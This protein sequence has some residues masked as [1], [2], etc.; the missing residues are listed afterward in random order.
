MHEPANHSPAALF[1]FAVISQVLAGVHIGEELAETIRAVAGRE[2]VGFDGASQRV[3]QR[4]IYRWL[5]AYRVGGLAG[6]EP[7]RHANPASRDPLPRKF[8]DFMVREKGQDPAAS[9]PE[10]IRRAVEC[11]ILKPDHELHRSTVHRAARRLGIPVARSKRARDRDARRFAYPH[12]M[13]MVLCDGKHFRASESRAKRVALFFLDD[14]TRLILHVVVGTAETAE[15]FQRGLYDCIARYGYMTAL[16]LDRGPGF[17]AQDTIGVLA[18]LGI[19]LIHGEA[20]YK[21]GRGKVERFNR[22]ITADVL[23]ALN[24]RPDVDAACSALELRLRHYADQVYARRPHESLGGE[25][26]QQRFS[27][28][29]RP[30]RWPH[31]HQQLRAMFEVWIDRRVSNDHVVSIDSIDYE[32]PRGYAGRIVTLRRRLLERTIGFLHEGRVIDLLPVDPAANARAPRARD[33]SPD[34]PHPMPPVTA[35]ELSFRRDFGP[36]VDA[37]GGFEGPHPHDPVEQ[38]SDR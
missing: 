27:A 7:R 29:P 16:Y 33:T 32:M 31:D 30:L 25:S 3:S 34:E 24:G 5:A 38:E 11:G 10:L 17:I 19:P 35:A 23:R 37:D 28:D 20:G 36:I 18:R 13:D 26:P 14:A 6:L 15:L 2:H 12:R 4:S 9:I 1:R 21:E 8:V 22:T